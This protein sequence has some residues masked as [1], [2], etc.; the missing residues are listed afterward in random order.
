MLVEGILFGLA[1]YGFVTLWIQL[2]KKVAW[3]YNHSNTE[4]HIM[5]L[6][7][8]AESY[9][10]HLYRSLVTMSRATGRPLVLTFVDCGSQDDTLRMLRLLTKKDDHVV[11]LEINQLE[12][13]CADYLGKQDSTI[14][15]DLRLSMR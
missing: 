10:E 13:P 14:M 6:L 9:I 2:L 4:M 1:I 5:I 7:H 8:D 11:I 3:W 12:Q 15:I